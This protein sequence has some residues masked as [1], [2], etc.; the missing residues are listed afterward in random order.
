MRFIL[1]EHQITQAESGWI[2]PSHEWV[3]ESGNANGE[4]KTI[5]RNKTRIRLFL[6]FCFGII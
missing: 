4:R 2:A 3:P 6:G 1:L 5:L